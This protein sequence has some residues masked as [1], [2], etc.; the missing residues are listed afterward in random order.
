MGIYLIQGLYNISLIFFSSISGNAL[1]KTERKGDS[2]IG[3]Y[4]Q[5]KYAQVSFDWCSNRVAE[6]QC[7]EYAIFK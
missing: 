4:R 2:T 6:V 5:K 3:D 7:P 1:P